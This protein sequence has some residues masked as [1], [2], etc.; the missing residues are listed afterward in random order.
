M[1]SRGGLSVGA[2]HA[3]PAQYVSGLSPTAARPRWQPYCS[4]GPPLTM[5]RDD[6]DESQE[7]KQ[8]RQKPMTILITLVLLGPS[9]DASLRGHEAPASDTDLALPCPQ[10][11]ALGQY[12][13]SK[14]VRTTTKECSPC[15]QKTRHKA[16]KCV[17]TTALSKRKGI[18]NTPRTGLPD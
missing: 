8:V 1:V 7:Q 4:G 6:R 11:R 17:A 12:R 15:R 18:Q 2:A 13:V 10:G 5:D 14:E 9:S 3:T 16:P